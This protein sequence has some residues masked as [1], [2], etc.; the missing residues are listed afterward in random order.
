MSPPSSKREVVCC[1]QGTNVSQ[2][3]ILKVKISK[4]TGT[5]K[6]LK[7]R[8]QNDTLVIKISATLL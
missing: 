2:V 1:S 5:E 8:C 6:A 7:V 3:I 4:G